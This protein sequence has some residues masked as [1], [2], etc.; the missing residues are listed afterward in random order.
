M[1]GRILG[2]PMVVTTRCAAAG[3]TIY[4]DVR[5]GRADNAS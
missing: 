4:R 3:G 2:W 5:E 1:A